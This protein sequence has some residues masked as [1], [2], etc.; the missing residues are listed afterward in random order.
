[1]GK[2]V[3]ESPS[4]SMPTPKKAKKPGGTFRDLPEHV[5]QT[6]R[7][8]RGGRKAV[9]RLCGSCLVPVLEGMDADRCAWTVRVDPTPLTPLEEVLCVLADRPTYTLRIGERMILDY[10]DEYGVGKPSAQLVVPGHLCGA[11]F[12]STLPRPR[13]AAAQADAPPF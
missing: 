7:E 13:A 6:I 8:Q 12:G 10:R 4:D 11:R 3:T 1:M 5:Q 9:Y 2:Q